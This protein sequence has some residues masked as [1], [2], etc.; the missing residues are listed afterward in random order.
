MAK[1][2][3]LKIGERMETGSRYYLKWGKKKTNVECSLDVKAKQ[4]HKKYDRQVQI[5]T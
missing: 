3:L 4:T 5:D 2:T 1:L